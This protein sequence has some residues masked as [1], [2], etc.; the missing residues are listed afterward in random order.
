MSENL[1]I[2]ARFYRE[3]GKAASDALDKGSFAF[4]LTLAVLALMLSMFGMGVPLRLA[5]FG[6]AAIFLV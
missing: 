3:P 1:A 6:M 4:A 5:F 2:F